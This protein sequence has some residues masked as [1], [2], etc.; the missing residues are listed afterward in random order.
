[1]RK[2]EKGL[3]AGG[4][5]GGGGGGAGG[6]VGGGGGWGFCR[7]TRGCHDLVLLLPRSKLLDWTRLTSTKT[8]SSEQE[9]FLGPVRKHE[10]PFLAGGPP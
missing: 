1:M 9:W 2:K 8:L 3:R 10:I 6:G 4:R 7:P 5:G